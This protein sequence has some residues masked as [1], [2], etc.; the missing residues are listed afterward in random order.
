MMRL[1]LKIYNK[2]KNK[3][4]KLISK[5]KSFKGFTVLNFKNILITN[6]LELRFLFD[7]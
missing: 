4:K 2:N 3:N 1:Q 6:K 5:T 7:I